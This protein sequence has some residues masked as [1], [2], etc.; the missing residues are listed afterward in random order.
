MAKKTQSKNK[1]GPFSSQGR[2]RASPHCHAMTLPAWLDSEDVL[3]VGPMGE[4]R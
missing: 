3:D 2:T 1:N 4:W